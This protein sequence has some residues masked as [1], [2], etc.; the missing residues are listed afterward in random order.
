[1]DT[2][3]IIAQRVTAIG[4]DE[5]GT[6]LTARLFRVGSELMVETLPEWEAGRIDAMPQN[7]SSATMTMLLKREDGEIYWDQKADYIAR[8]VRA[9][10]PWP[11][12]FT[13]WH[14]KL[15]KIVEAAVTEHTADAVPG[16]VIALSSDS[17]DIATADG[18]LEIKR[19]QIE[20]AKTLD[21][22]EFVRGHPDIVG[23]ILENK[24]AR[25]TS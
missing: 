4:A 7:D 9:Y 11:G 16:R 3:P 22:V 18:T 8:Q 20:G 15:L 19:L 13:R 1:M 10:Q 14:G 6:A 5:D 17:L 25:S 24:D 2:G 12:V 21:A 23:S